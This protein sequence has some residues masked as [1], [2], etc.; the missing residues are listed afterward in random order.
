MSEWERFFEGQVPAYKDAS[1]NKNTTAEVNF[2]LEVFNLPPGSR[3]LAV[4]CGVGRHSN[5]STP[6]FACARARSD[7]WVWKM[8]R[9]SMTW[10]FCAT[11][12]LRLNRAHD[13]F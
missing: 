12:T 5:Y 11:F 3:V 7:C 4:G 13:L 2:L 8:T 6:Q 9:P 10:I 1:F